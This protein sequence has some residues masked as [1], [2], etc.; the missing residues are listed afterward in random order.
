MIN[1][2][3][4][5]YLPK[6]LIS[7]FRYFYNKTVPLVYY[8]ERKV[9]LHTYAGFPLN[10][11]I[12]NQ[13]SRTW[14]DQDWQRGEIDFLRQGKLKKGATVFDIG[15]HHGIVALI[16]SKIVGKKGRVIAVEM[17]PNHVEVANINKNNNS[18]S[19]LHIIQAAVTEKTGNVSF[20][21]DQILH[22]T[23]RKNSTM[24]HSISVDDF[25]KKYGE[26]S[27]L[28]IDVEGYE[29]QVLKGAEKTLLQYH[30]DCCIEVHVNNGLEN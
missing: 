6:P 29:C 17:D 10:I 14:Y 8:L 2:S 13:V 4:K 3:L 20:A 30:P 15:A 1:K 22:K 16:F 25:T 21:H 23:S 26:P 24:T 7:L 28:Y 5:K 27:V 12:F 18:A 11:Y 9:K 19:N